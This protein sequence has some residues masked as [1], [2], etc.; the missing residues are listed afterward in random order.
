MIAHRLSTVRNA[1]TIFMVE[2]GQIVEAGSHDELVAM[3]GAYKKLVS[4]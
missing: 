3:G 2:D 4:K 1:D